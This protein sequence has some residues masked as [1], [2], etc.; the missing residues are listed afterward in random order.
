MHRFYDQTVAILI[1][2]SMAELDRCMRSYIDTER[3]LVYFFPPR[4]PTGVDGP[5]ITLMYQPGGVL[6]V[7]HDAQNVTISDISVVNGRHA[8]ILA[9]GG[10]T[11]LNI[12]RVA[13]HAHGT[14][15]I[16]HLQACGGSIVD[17]EVYDVGCSGIRATAGSAQTLQVGGIAVHHNH[18]ILYDTYYTILLRYYMILI[19]Y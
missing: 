19:I 2:D 18:D 14:H 16:V 11:G 15:G 9:E 10:V 4:P 17:C 1:A 7:T 3:L 12:E 6:N 13:V 5:P 8:G